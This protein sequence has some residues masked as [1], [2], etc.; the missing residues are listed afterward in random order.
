MAIENQYLYQI[1]NE[2]VQGPFD[3]KSIIALA[4][5]G[6]IP[7]DAQIRSTL[8]P[9]WTKAKDVDF[10]K[11]IYRDLL[12]KMAEA[13]SQSEKVRREAKMNL[14]GD[15]DPMGTALSQEGIIYET[16]TPIARTLA[17]VT[18]L[19]VE[20]AGALVIMFFCWLLVCI[21]LLPSSIAMYFFLILVWTGVSIYNIWT[22]NVYGQTY[23]MRFWGLVAITPDLRPVYCCRAY[24][25]FL[26]VC[27]IG[28]F[29]P[30]TWVL[31]GGRYS[32]QEYLVGLRI[33]RIYV[34]RRPY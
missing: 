34:A 3:E 17:A 31:T 13:H 10:L 32:L 29:T 21:H 6:Q 18:D 20:A 28:I 4:Q 8:L 27:L 7:H 23:G 22:L 30:V 26:L 24:A 1:G 14:R 2:P 9:I 5:S 19:L 12:L 33:R 15:Y 25:Y 11:T 16:T